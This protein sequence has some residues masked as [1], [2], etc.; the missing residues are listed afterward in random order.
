MRALVTGATGF[1]GSHMVE[2][3]LDQGWEVVCPVRDLNVLNHLKGINT[4]VIP[5]DSLEEKIE[6]GPELDY[7]IHIAGATRAPN[8]VTFQKANVSRNC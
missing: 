3:L 7:V 5:Y 4:V 1:I 8:Y 2:L 6:N